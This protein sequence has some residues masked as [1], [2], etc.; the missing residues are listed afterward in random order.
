MTSI[1]RRFT[2]A[3][4]TL[5]LLGG[6]LAQAADLTWHAAGKEGAI[7][8]EDPKAVAA[9]LEMLQKGGNATDAAVACML[10]AS[11]MDYGMFCIGA[12]VP[13]MI[14]DANKKEVKTLSGLGGAP[15]NPES[16]KWYYDNAIPGGGGMKA[17]PVPGALSL[18]FTALQKYGTMD[19][20]TV[21][22]P[23]LAILDAG[24]QDWYDELATTLRKLSA[25]EQKTEG[26]RVQKLQAA[27][28]RFYKG[29]IAAELV[30]YYRKGGSLLRKRDLA[31]HETL[32]EDPVSVSYRGYQVYK[33]GPWTQ[34]PYLCQTLKILEGFDLK[35]MGHLSADYIHCLTEAL[36]LGL[37]DRDFYYGDPRFAKVPMAALLSEEYAKLR[38][39]LIDMKKASMEVRP[40]D[41]VAMKAL[42]SEPGKYR[43]GPG[44]TTT[45]VVADRWGNFV[46]ATPSGNSP[47]HVCGPLGIAHG[48][49]LRSLN[50]TPGHPNRIEPGKRPRITLTPT[51]VLKDGAP[52]M[53]ISVA[54]GDLQDQTTLNCF[55]NVV[56]FGMKPQEAV[57]SARFSTRHHENSFDPRKD[58]EIDSL[59]RLT[60]QSSIPDPIRAQLA[61]RGHKLGSAGGAIA[62]P[63]MILYDREK[64]TFYAAGDPKAHRHAAVLQ[65]AP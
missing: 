55:L 61:E 26:A 4:L 33:C 63:V 30:A 43:P 51:L 22:Q 5:F 18:F 44:G 65:P 36:K 40:G 42:H 13:F 41:P 35:P 2:S 52:V 64:K 11:I 20:T 14:Y 1:L 37:A 50:T 21:V 32:L 45:C 6:P 23:T 15:L 59:G 48:N 27:R 53:A 29:D 38:R 60:L 31:A 57:S 39:P 3:S 17:I 16:I 12:E 46:S 49:R 58:R 56:E 7:A 62:N 10:V 25:T 28:D 9:G 19:F 24:G 34:G 47:Y 8:A 54:G